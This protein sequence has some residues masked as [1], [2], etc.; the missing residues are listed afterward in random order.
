MSMAVT[1]VRLGERRFSIPDRFGDLR[2]RATSR[3][4]CRAPLAGLPF[5]PVSRDVPPGGSEPQARDR[6]ELLVEQRTC[7]EYHDRAPQADQAALP[8]G[9]A[10]W[11]AGA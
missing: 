3:R 11:R 9:E 7:D 8:D 1:S 6:N 2:D 5:A 4:R 10:W